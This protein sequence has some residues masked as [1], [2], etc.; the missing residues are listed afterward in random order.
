MTNIFDNKYNDKLKSIYIIRLCRFLKKQIPIVTK[1]ELRKISNKCKLLKINGK[2]LKKNRYDENIISSIKK[3]LSEFLTLSINKNVIFMTDIK[4][5][6]K[7]TYLSNGNLEI[8][9]LAKLVKKNFIRQ[10][11][12]E[13]EIE[14]RIWKIIN[15]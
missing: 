10:L 5:I 6:G 2:K 11:D 3:I 4:V 1:D 9:T 13:E 8:Q 12:E 15:S 14:R 7:L